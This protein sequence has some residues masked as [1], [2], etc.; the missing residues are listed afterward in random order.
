MNIAPADGAIEPLNEPLNAKLLRIAGMHPGTSL[1]YLTS[2]VAMS[3]A[4]VKRAVAAK[5]TSSDGLIDDLSRVRC[6]VLACQ[7][8]Q[9]AQ[10]LLVLSK[11][12][13]T[14]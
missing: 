9:H 4:I 2:T 5:A 12:S 13:H 11:S 10:I 1:P 7:P 3:R 6:R 14:V 8:F